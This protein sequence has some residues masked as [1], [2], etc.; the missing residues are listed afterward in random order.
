MI[1]CSYSCCACRAET[2]HC[3]LTHP[4]NRGDFLNFDFLVRSMLCIFC[5]SIACC[6]GLAY[7]LTSIGYLFTS[8]CCD[9]FIISCLYCLKLC[10]SLS[11]AAVAYAWHRWHYYTLHDMGNRSH[12]HMSHTCPLV[13]DRKHNMT[14]A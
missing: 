1:T 5:S 10:C 9:V 7:S 12:P 4:A 3:S 6:L 14:R 11:A 2:N 8:K 13:V